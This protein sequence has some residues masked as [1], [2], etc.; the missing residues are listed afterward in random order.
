M[1]LF[2]CNDLFFCVVSEVSDQEQSVI[3]NETTF[4]IKL[5]SE[6]TC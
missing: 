1:I 5:Q 4:V 6:C 3:W 2:L